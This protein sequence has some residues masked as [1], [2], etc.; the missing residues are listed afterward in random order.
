MA[1]SFLTTNIIAYTVGI[2][3]QRSITY[4][5]SVIFLVLSSYIAIQGPALYVANWASLVRLIM[6]VLFSVVFGL[7]GFIL[8]SMALKIDKF[9]KLKGDWGLVFSSFVAILMCGASMVLYDIYGMTLGLLGSGFLLLM[10]T[11]AFFGFNSLAL[12]SRDQGMKRYSQQKQ[13]EELDSGKF[14]VPTMRFLIEFCGL[15]YGGMFLTHVLQA[16]VLFPAFATYPEEFT[17]IVQALALLLMSV[18]FYF[19]YNREAVK[20]KARKLKQ[21]AKQRKES[22]SVSDDVTV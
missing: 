13:E 7:A 11:L 8:S 14:V 10:S 2:F 6:Q 16:F 4:P 21:K 18:V 17:S 19:I 9:I 3:V 1:I 15:W 5:P 22:K 20:E 12:N